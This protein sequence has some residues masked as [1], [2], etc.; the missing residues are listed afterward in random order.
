MKIF[1]EEEV[2]KAALESY[3]YLPDWACKY[4][5]ELTG[6]CFIVTGKQIGRAHV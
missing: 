5:D 2:D 6:A 3:S 1:D 4:E